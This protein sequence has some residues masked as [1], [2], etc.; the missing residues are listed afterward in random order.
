MFEEILKQRESLYGEGDGSEGS[1]ENLPGKTKEFDNT[2]I[3]N[4]I[5]NKKKAYK[6]VKF[7]TQIEVKEQPLQNADDSE[8][9]YADY[10]DYLD[11]KASRMASCMNWWEADVYERNIAIH[12]KR[13]F[14]CK[15]K[16]C[17]N[18]KTVEVA[19]NISKVAGIVKELE[20][21]HKAYLMT[22]TAPNVSRE[23]YA[24]MVDKL[25]KKFKNLITLFSFSINSKYAYKGRK[26]TI[27]GAI[28]SIETTYN[29]YE[30]TYHPHIHAMVFITT[31]NFEQFEKI[32]KGEYNR[33]TR[34]YNMISDADIELRQIWTR[35]YNDVDRRQKDVDLDGYMCDIRPIEDFKGILEVLK[36]SFK[37]RDIDSYEVF[38]TLYHGTYRRRMKQG[39]GCLY[40]LKLEDDGKETD[41]PEALFEEIPEPAKLNLRYLVEAYNGYT[42]FTNFQTLNDIVEY[43]K[44]Q[45][46]D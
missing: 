1:I 8:M 10:T 21:K 32:H 39:Y 22:L 41:T 4:L 31:Q 18:C 7:M 6:L 15:S 37:T 28:R 26:Y 24:D 34:K 14:R 40:N 11:S 36:Y 44:P 13:T 17:P 46:E 29:K 2:K 33:K 5:Q 3:L 9:D 43:I 23:E 35:L 38:S 42:K 12:L 45:L 19:K 30:Q 27:V 16:F 20:Q 25:C